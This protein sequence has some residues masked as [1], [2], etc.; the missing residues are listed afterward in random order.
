[1]SRDGTDD[2]LFDA[3]EGP[4]VATVELGIVFLCYQDLVGVRKWSVVVGADGE[5]AWHLKEEGNRRNCR[6]LTQR[7]FGS[8]VHSSAL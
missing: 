3:A 4:L 7:D 5:A 2:G 8:F 1:M 6:D